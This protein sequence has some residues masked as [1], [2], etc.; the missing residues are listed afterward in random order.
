[1]AS[2]KK[3]TTAAAPRNSLPRPLESD[4]D[5]ASVDLFTDLHKKPTSSKPA[6]STAVTITQSGVT[7]KSHQR[8]LP[9][10][11]E[12]MEN[13]FHIVKAKSGGHA[14]QFFVEAAANNQSVWIIT[15]PSTTQL[16]FDLETTVMAQESKS[17]RRVPREVKICIPVSHKGGVYENIC[18][19]PPHP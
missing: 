15:G 7:R 4:S 10:G 1:L 13:D 11:P 18:E 19:L 3:N 8:P 17:S 14:V 12:T 5:T 2:A 6:S 9:Q 16:N